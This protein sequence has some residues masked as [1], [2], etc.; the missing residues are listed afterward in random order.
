ML[1]SICQQ[2]RILIN[3]HRT[4]KSQFSSQSQKRAMPKNVKAIEQLC[5]FLMLVKL[6]SKSF[7]LGFSSTWIESFQMYKL[8]LKMTE[9][10]EIKL[11][12]YVGSKRKQRNSRKK[13]YF[14]FVDCTKAFDC[15]DHNKLWKVFKEMET[16]DHLTCLLRKLHV[17]QETTVRV[18]QGTTD[19]FK[20][21][22]WLG[23]GSILS[24]VCLTSMQSTSCEMPGWISYKL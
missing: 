10:S 13:V 19:L 6:Y 14:C 17:G 20:I 2:N 11:S 24:P 5:S 3:S 9:K 15:V 18:L 12:I 1:F 22:K 16:S 7:K 21:G 23:Q 4:G 8:A